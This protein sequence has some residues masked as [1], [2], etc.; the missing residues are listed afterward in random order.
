[1]P[2]AIPRP[3]KLVAGATSGGG[4]QNAAWALTSGVLSGQG[5][6]AFARRQGRRAAE[7]IRPAGTVA[8]HPAG[9]VKAIDQQA[10]VRRVQ[11]QILPLEKALWR[12]GKELTNAETLLEDSWREIVAHGEASDLDIVAARETAALVATA[13]WC[14][15]AAL[16][17]EESRGIHLRADAPGSS[18]ELASRLLV[19]GLDHL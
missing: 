1:M 10:I 8:L 14:T 11:D 9:P 5:A 13:R 19:G 15:A 17:R 12:T 4:A 7:K 3:A 16:A 2:R 18:P 6:A